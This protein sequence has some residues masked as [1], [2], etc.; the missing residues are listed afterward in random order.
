MLIPVA[1]WSN[2]KLES[3]NRALGEITDRIARG[4]KMTTKKVVEISARSS[5][6]ART[7]EGL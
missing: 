7:E 4:E 3:F 5:R 1:N 2:D 6:A